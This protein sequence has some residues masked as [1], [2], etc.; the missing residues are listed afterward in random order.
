MASTKSKSSRGSGNPENMNQRSL[1]EFSEAKAARKKNI[2]REIQEL[3]GYIAIGERAVQNLHH[4]NTDHDVTTEEAKERYA[5]TQIEK[6]KSK[7]AEIKGKIAVLRQELEL[8]LSGQLD[9]AIRRNVQ[10]VKSTSLDLRKREQEKYQHK[11][12][13]KRKTQ[14]ALTDKRENDREDRRAYWK[15]QREMNYFQRHFDRTTP[16]S[17]IRKNLRDFTGNKGYIW[18][19]IQF[20]GKRPAQPGAPVV[21]FEPGKNHLTIH[22]WKGNYYRIYR[23]V[24]RARR[25]P[26]IFEERRRPGIAEA[27]WGNRRV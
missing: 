10:T 19:G 24:G 15:K 7:I 18:R 25:G 12:D 14:K 6:R 20:F 11:R 27:F 23:K 22:E 9:D 5:K 17:H 13:A 8:L 4:F 1:R 3:E 21:L 2:F 26:P 16:P